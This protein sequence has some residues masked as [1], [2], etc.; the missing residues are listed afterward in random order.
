MIYLI[1]G[2]PGAGKTL[3]AV[4]LIEGWAKAG[5]PV[6]ARIDGL[7]MPGVQ[8][9]PDDWRQ[10]PDGSVVV[11]DEAQT[12][13]G[14]EG[15][16]TGRSSRADIQA[17]ETHRHTGHDLVLV[18]Q[19]PGLLHS[20]VRRLVG[21]H[22]HVQRVFGSKRV[23]IAW[24]DRCFDV[25]SRAERSTA[26]TQSWVHPTRLFEVYKSAS[27]HV[28]HAKL[29]GRVKWLAGFAVACLLLLGIAVSRLLSGPSQS[30]L[31]EQAT[32]VDG[33][34]ERVEAAPAL[35]ESAPDHEPVKPW[36][37]IP[38]VAGCISTTTR[39]QCYTA[40]GWPIDQDI[41]ECMRFVSQPLPIKLAAAPLEHRADT[42][43]QPAPD[44]AQRSEAAAPVAALSAS[45]YS[46]RDPVAL[47]GHVDPV[48]LSAGPARS[49][50]V[51]APVS[52][53]SRVGVVGGGTRPV[54]GP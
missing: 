49:V 34:V 16:K 40:Q 35:S 52:A 19:H 39:C 13:F 50:T 54:F 9:A 10:T 38:V 46:G 22:E 20:H 44:K 21:R 51:S 33:A 17:M 43:R 18:T 4:E 11:Y 7:T 36:K 1:T 53:P 24:R 41:G 47:T 37:V 48:A 8:E 23:V 15:P 26:V 5:R 30:D 45:S 2:V 29:P 27:V 3:R 32:G 42:S 28:S 14:A 31:I 25:D 6:F 12:L